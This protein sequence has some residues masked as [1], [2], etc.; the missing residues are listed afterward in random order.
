MLFHLT[1]PAHLIPSLVVC[2]YSLRAPSFL[3]QFIPVLPTCVSPLCFSPEPL[4]SSVFE[5][6]PVS[7][8]VP[9]YVLVMC[10]PRRLPRV[11][12]PNLNFAFGCTLY[13][14]LMRLLC[15][16][17]FAV[18]GLGLFICSS[19]SLFQVFYITPLCTVYLV[20]PYSASL[21]N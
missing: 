5:C 12:F 19:L 17:V 7:A 13:E 6:I 8:R 20:P 3:C 4:P 18:L 16:V 1:P 21:T 2:V 10:V 11:F 9:T 14:V 15:F